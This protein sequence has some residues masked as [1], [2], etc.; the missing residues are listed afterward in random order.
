ML[1]QCGE[2]LELGDGERVARVGDTGAAPQGAPQP[3]DPG[4]QALGR[5]RCSDG[6]PGGSSP[7]SPAP[8]RSRAAVTS[9][10]PSRD[11][12]TSEIVPGGALAGACLMSRQAACREDQAGLAYP[13]VLGIP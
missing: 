13:V 12:A 11:R 4:G 5:Q 9:Q 10:L 7:G 1:G 6:S 8:R 3:G 2:Q